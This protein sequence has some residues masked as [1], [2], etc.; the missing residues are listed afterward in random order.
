MLIINNSLWSLQSA[1][2][3]RLEGRRERGGEEGESTGIEREGGR[4][5]E[6]SDRER[7]GERERVQGERDR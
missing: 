3:P 5:R 1:H 7:G 4:E 6:C 2:A